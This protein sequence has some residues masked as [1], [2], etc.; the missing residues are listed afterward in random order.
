M[1]EYLRG[2]AVDYV[3]HRDTLIHIHLSN[4][5]AGPVTVFGQ[6]LC[7]VLETVGLGALIAKIK[8]RALPA[9]LLKN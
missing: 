1:P 7:R 3:Y 8:M 6:Q 4:G 5:N 9:R 2:V